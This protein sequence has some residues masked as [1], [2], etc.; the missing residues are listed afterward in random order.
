MRDINRVSV[1]TYAMRAKSSPSHMSLRALLRQAHNQ[2]KEST[3]DKR[4]S[5]HLN[6]MTLVA[7]IGK[8]IPIPSAMLKFVDEDK[9]KSFILPTLQVCNEAH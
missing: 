2:P 8:K 1:T 6:P 4:K 9:K 7:Q 5:A 3:N